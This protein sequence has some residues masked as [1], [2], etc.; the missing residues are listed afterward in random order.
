MGVERVFVDTNVLVYA[1]DRSAGAKRGRAVDLLQRV[2]SRG[3]GCV[4]MQVLQ[5]FYVNSTRKVA[6]PLDARVAR[7]IVAYLGR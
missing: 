5:E 3:N 2:W 6:E 7:S 4:S 1:F